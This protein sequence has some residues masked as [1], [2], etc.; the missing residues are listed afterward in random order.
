VRRACPHP[1]VAAQANQAPLL[2]FTFFPCIFRAIIAY[3]QAAFFGHQ[4]A[5]HGT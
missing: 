2:F 4:E 1:P 3:Q 5:F